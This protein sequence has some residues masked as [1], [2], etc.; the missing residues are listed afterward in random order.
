M[1]LVRVP[2]SQLADIFTK[3][4]QYPQGQA[5]VEGILGRTFKPSKGTSDLKRG[6]IAESSGDG[7]GSQAESR[8]PLRGVL[9]HESGM[10]RPEL[11]IIARLYSGPDEA[12]DSDGIGLSQVVDGSGP[13]GQAKYRWD[14]F[15]PAVSD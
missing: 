11:D 4:L 1:L 3:G 8:R 6:W 2:T 5:C 13:M 15:I 14:L 9:R 10:P 7:Q 12:H